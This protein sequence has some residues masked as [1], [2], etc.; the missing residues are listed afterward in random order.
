MTNDWLS[1][2][3]AVENIKRLLI[4]TGAPLEMRV[5]RIC[6]AQAERFPSSNS[7]STS[8]SSG[9]L[10][11]GDEPEIPLREIDQHI[12]SLSHL[13]TGSA[14][15]ISVGCRVLIECKHRDGLAVFGFPY[16]SR[17]QP[18]TLPPMFGDLAFTTFMGDIDAVALPL[19]RQPLCSI[20]LLDS[21]HK[22]PRVSDEQLIYKA[23]AS[24]YDA[25]RW[26]AEPHLEQQPDPIIAEIGLMDRFA[27]V[28]HPSTETWGTARSWLHHRLTAEE[29]E[30]YNARFY[31]ED[32][33]RLLS[34][35]LSVYIPLVCVDAPLYTVA[36]DDDGAI[37]SITPTNALVTGL[38]LP[39]W[40]GR[41]EEHLRLSPAEARIIVV[42]VETL[43]DILDHL[44]M[45]LDKLCYVVGGHDH[46][47]IDEQLPLQLGFL[48]SVRHLMATRG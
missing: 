5:A 10:L 23:G 9:R 13:D 38:R 43:P 44:A 4:Q 6:N 11:Y 41:F 30:A 7:H 16:E 46:Q 24:L 37:A 32:P 26:M 18:I 48:R 19:L 40:P 17:G 34:T 3:K 8:W 21:M 14:V 47:Q 31:A 12:E 39:R 22:A 36:L 25:I 33:D 20:G 15:D 1:N 45:W 29:Y 42:N 2:P 35:Y 28:A 27:A